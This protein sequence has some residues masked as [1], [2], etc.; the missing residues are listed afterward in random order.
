[1]LKLCSL[2]LARKQETVKHFFSNYFKEENNKY[3]NELWKKLCCEKSDISRYIITNIEST[4]RLY[5][6]VFDNIDSTETYLSEPE[7]EINILKVY[8]LF[9]E[10]KNNAENTASISTENIQQ[11]RAKALMLA[12]MFQYFDIVNYSY[13][14]ELLV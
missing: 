14:Q 5:E 2:F 10:I 8:L 7:I 13:K 12:Q 3:I 6:F 1:M 4:L 9:N 11:D